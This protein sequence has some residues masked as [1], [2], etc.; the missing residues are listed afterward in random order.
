MATE[1]TPYIRRAMVKIQDKPRVVELFGI[2]RV[3]IDVVKI[4]GHRNVEIEL[5]E[6]KGLTDTAQDE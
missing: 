1:R 5:V 3:R 6:L 4:K 2:M